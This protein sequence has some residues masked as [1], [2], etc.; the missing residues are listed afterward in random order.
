MYR[1]RHP[2]LHDPRQLFTIDYIIY[3]SFFPESST[4]YE[5]KLRKSFSSFC[6]SDTTYSFT[7]EN[8]LLL[9][10]CFS[11]VLDLIQCF[12]FFKYV[13]LFS[14]QLHKI[15]IVFFM[16]NIGISYLRWL[17]TVSSTFQDI[18]FDGSLLPLFIN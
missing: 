4:V 5:K 17:K 3:F 11:L 13:W 6:E 16:I 10:L 9:L 7:V 14:L 1:A 12:R 15:E 18:D 2:T 8:Y